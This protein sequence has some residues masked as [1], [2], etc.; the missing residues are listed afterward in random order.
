MQEKNKEEFEDLKKYLNDS[1]TKENVLL[2]T[3]FFLAIKSVE[4]SGNLLLSCDLRDIL[5]KM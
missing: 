5:N 4:D 1:D 2:K 3:G